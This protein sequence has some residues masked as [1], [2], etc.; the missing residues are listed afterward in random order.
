[1]DGRITRTRFRTSKFSRQQRNHM[2]KQMTM[3]IGVSTT[4]ES[5]ETFPTRILSLEI[6][7]WI[8]PV[9]VRS[10]PGINPPMFDGWFFCTQSWPLPK[11]SGQN[12]QA[13]QFLVGGTLNPN[14]HGDF[15]YMPGFPV[16]LKPRIRRW[17]WSQV[18]KDREFP[19]FEFY[20]VTLDIKT[21]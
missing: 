19:T 15:W 5:G 14:S 21:L 1:M 18:A 12:L 8:S 13:F 2:T 9:K 7:W 10:R 3:I 16:A 11:N 6:Y 4:G 20:S 17:Q